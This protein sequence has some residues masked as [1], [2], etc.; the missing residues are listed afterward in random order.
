MPSIIVHFNP[1]NA[2]VLD[3]FSHFAEAMVRVIED[4]LD[5]ERSKIQIMS[6]ALAHPPIGRPVYIEIKARDVEYRT[7]E[8]LADFISRVDELSREVFETPCR[9]RY[10]RYPSAFLVAAN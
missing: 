2:A 6:Q 3:G 8:V 9:I 1:A 5:A 7:D 10:I 4:C